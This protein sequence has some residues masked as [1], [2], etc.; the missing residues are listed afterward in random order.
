MW[1][2]PPLLPCVPLVPRGDG[3][4]SMHV[5]F[6]WLYYQS[7]GTLAAVVGHPPTTTRTSRRTLES[8]HGEPF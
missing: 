1:S 6:W 5:H 7:H 2:D 3:V 4:E 8:S